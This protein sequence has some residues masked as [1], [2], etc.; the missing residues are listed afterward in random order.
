LHPLI[1]SKADRFDPRCIAAVTRYID[2][3]STLNDR[4]YWPVRAFSALNLFLWHLDAFGRD[5]D[6]IPLFVSAFE[7]ATR[8]LEEADGANVTAM[9]F[10]APEHMD[11]EGKR[12]E[13]EVSG[14]FS[15]IWLGMTDD[16][17]FDESFD[18]LRQRLEKNGVDPHDLFGGKVVV[19]AG[20]GSGKFSAAIARFEPAKVIGIDIGDRGLE[21]ARRQA[22]KVPHG[23]RIEYRLGSLLE[24]PLADASV[25]VVLSNGVIH[26]TTD[27]ERCIAE[28]A[29]VIKPGGTLFL[30][31][32]G[33]FGLFELLVDTTRLSL[34]GVPRAFYLHYLSLL[35]LNSG[36]I[37]WVADN[38]YA[39]YEWKSDE[40]VQALLRL[41]GFDDI[42]RL[43]R[44]VPSD[45]IEQ[46][47]TGL[48]YAEVKYGESQLKYLARRND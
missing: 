45:Q 34:Q 16:I 12:F 48:P 1:A 43:Y 32:N 29:R 37:Y 15:D 6:P 28:F 25:D 38:S 30:Y 47:S 36:R 2:V 39:P 44:G 24:I 4:I 40:D 22:E 35:G 10:P 13:E 20:C 8:F 33:L 9:A 27:Y 26:H 19:D 7:G 14:L 11:P 41:H 42:R 23:K 21:F 46:V 17:Y 18:F 5:E 3:C 31:V